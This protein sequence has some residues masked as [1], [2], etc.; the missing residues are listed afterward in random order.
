MVGFADA[1]SCLFF[2]TQDVGPVILGIPPVDEGTIVGPSM[3][4]G[5]PRSKTSVRRARTKAGG[6]KYVI[7]PANSKDPVPEGYI[8]DMETS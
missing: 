6:G 7:L 1:T 5:R 8:A 3:T 2:D 4:P